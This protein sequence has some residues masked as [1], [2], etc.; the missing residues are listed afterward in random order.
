VTP[1]LDAYKLGLKEIRKL[2]KADFNGGGSVVYLA[3]NK[4]KDNSHLKKLLEE[5]QINRDRELL[6][7]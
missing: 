6:L 4:G 5:N 7:L 2:S 3:N 1:E